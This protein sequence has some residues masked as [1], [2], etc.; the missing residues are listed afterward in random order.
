MLH[1][2]IRGERKW[3]NNTASG[4]PLVTNANHPGV[5]VQMLVQT[6]VP[7]RPHSFDIHY[8]H[9]SLQ[10][11][12]TYRYLLLFSVAISTCREVT[13]YNIKYQTCQCSCK[14]AGNFKRNDFTPL[15]TAQELFIPRRITRKVLE[16][17]TNTQLHN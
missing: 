13:G 16:H 8:I 9:R 17:C 1:A 10:E 11:N 12:N 15:I 4:Y 14:M 2:Y 3:F 7:S 6:S 5:S